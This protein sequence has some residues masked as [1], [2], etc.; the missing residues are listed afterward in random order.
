MKI[1]KL[2]DVSNDFSSVMKVKKRFK[3]SRSDFSGGGSFGPGMGEYMPQNFVVPQMLVPV[4]S[5]RVE[6]VPVTVRVCSYCK[7]RRGSAV[8]TCDG[9]G[10]RMTEVENK[11]P[12]L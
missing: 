7:S 11:C 6:V 4:S 3:I 5:A 1:K 2:F 12:A 8:G 9:C 10:A